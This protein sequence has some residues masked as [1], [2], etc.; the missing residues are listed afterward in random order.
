[1][2]TQTRHPSSYQPESDDSQYD[3]FQLA[4][5][6]EVSSAGYSAEAHSFK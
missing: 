5:C 4:K 2:T 1:M 6:Y 3:H